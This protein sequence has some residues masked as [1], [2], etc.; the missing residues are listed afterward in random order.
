MRKEAKPGRRIRP[1]VELLE[2]R[3]LLSG[4]VTVSVADGDLIVSGDAQANHLR[5]DQLGLGAGE[6][7]ITGESFTNV[8]GDGAPFVV[9][10]VTRDVWINL[11]G[12]KDKLILH[13]G[14]LPRDLRIS[15]AGGKDAVLIFSP[16]T[17]TCA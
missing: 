4:D 16:R 13:G 3:S 14:V 2:S 15:M 9:S 1:S 8:N 11:G 7:R 12:E 5:I 6:F 10:G 17:A